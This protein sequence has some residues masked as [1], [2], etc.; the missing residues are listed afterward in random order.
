MGI[1]LCAVPRFHW[2]FSR[3]KC[4][5]YSHWI[6][7]FHSTWHWLNVISFSHHQPTTTLKVR[8]HTQM[9]FLFFNILSV[10]TRCWS[11]STLQQTSAICREH[12]LNLRA[13]RPRTFPFYTFQKQ[14]HPLT[15]QNPE[16]SGE[17]GR[18]S[19]GVVIQLFNKNNNI[20]PLH[21]PL[22]IMSP[23]KM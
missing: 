17:G 20:H 23:L 6:R 8:F 18:Q 2:L 10:N 7:S 3:P 14:L 21:S 12:S 16:R 11:A 15:Q 22:M 9:P 19:S 5:F 13:R 1:L 4:Q